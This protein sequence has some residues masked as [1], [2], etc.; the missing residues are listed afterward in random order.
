MPKRWPTYAEKLVIWKAL[1][2]EPYPLQEPI[3]RS[4]AK[5]LHYYHVS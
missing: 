1:G 4:N 2:Y 3:H 5:V